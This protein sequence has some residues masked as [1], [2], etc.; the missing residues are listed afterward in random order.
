MFRA[1]PGRRF[2]RSTGDRL[3]KASPS[4]FGELLN[5]T[6]E[7][8]SFPQKTRAICAPASADENKGGRPGIVPRVSFKMLMI[9][10]L[11]GLE[12]ERQIASRRADFLSLR[13]LFGGTLEEGHARSHRRVSDRAAARERVLSS[14]RRSGAASTARALA[15]QRQAFA[16]V[17]QSLAAR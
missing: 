17:A 7:R 9:G 5:V 14:G 6:L 13:D 1:R 2:P 10:F 3:P 12:N 8:M 4:C 16:S 11:E 15:A